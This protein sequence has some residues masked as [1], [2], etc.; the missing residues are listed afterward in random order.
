MIFKLNNMYANYSKTSKQMSEPVIVATPSNPQDVDDYSQYITDDMS[1]DEIAKVFTELE[2]LKNTQTNS[3]GSQN[4]NHP[5]K[6]VRTNNVDHLWDLAEQNIYPMVVSHCSLYIRMSINGTP[7]NCLLDTGAEQNVISLATIDKFN[8]RSLV[9]NKFKGKVIGV[10]ESTKLGI[11]PYLELE[12]E[13][14]V[15]CPVNFTVLDNMASKD[16]ILGLPFMMFYNVVLNFEK[17][18]ASIMG[19]DFNLIIIEK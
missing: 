3:N 17:R 2:K 11:L 7:I 19:Q 10:G 4:N 13:N 6:H 18:T 15:H 1:A 5:P 9:D 8:L 16:I 12:M 14:G